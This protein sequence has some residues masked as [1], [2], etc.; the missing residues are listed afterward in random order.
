V[1]AEASEHRKDARE[2][3][4]L[5]PVAAAGWTRRRWTKGLISLSVYF[6]ADVRLDTLPRDALARPVIFAATI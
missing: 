4:R 3:R 6:I 2:V 1:G 5:R